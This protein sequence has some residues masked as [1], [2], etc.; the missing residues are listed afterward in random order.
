[1]I[2]AGCCGMAG[3]FGYESEHYDLSMKVG[4]LALFPAIRRASETYG[5]DFRVAAAGVSCQGQIQDGAGM[6]A[7]HPIQLVYELIEA[8]EV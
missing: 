5:E 2:E 6:K 3:A 4:E 7:L 8:T 1:M